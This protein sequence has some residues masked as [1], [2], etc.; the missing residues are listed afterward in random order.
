MFHSLSCYVYLVTNSIPKLDVL[1]PINMFFLKSS[2]R[3]YS[4]KMY[5]ALEASLV[6]STDTKWIA[7]KEK[8]SF[9]V[10]VTVT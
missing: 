6:K 2:L 8:V 4:K 9:I 10:I 1:G 3:L 5:T 7:V